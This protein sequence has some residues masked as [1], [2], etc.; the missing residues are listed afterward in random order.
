VLVCTYNHAR[1][2]P[3][4]LGAICEQSRPPEECIVV[5]DG[6]T[7][8]SVSVI[9]EFARR[10]PVVVFLWNVGNKGLMSSILTALGRA[11]QEYIVWAAADDRLLPRF[12]E[13]NLLVSRRAVPSR[14]WS[15]GSPSQGQSDAR[16]SA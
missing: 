8:D 14:S 3:E 13:R 5:D 6:T 9:E 16:R 4:S 15:A 11:S 2:L 12:L 10:Y 7:D 1:Y